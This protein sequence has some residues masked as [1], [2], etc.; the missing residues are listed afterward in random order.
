MI[1][2]TTFNVKR[3]VATEINLKDF[4]LL[5]KYH[6]TVTRNV[7]EDYKTIIQSEVSKAGYEI[8][9]FDEL[10]KIFDKMYVVNVQRTKY[11]S[12]KSE[13]SLW[14]YVMDRLDNH[15]KGWI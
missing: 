2:L 8:K 12:L 15:T 11:G 5:H 9:R 13:T 7:T 3:V 1:K 4:E 10:V 14:S 6:I